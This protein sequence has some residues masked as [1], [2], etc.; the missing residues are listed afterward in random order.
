V[1][2]EVGARG[3]ANA[4]RCGASPRRRA[5]AR[6]AKGGQLVH[7][8]GRASRAK[9]PVVERVD[10]SLELLDLD[11]VAAQ[12]GIHDGRGER[13]RVER[14]DLREVVDLVVEPLERLDPA[15]ADGH[16]EVRRDHEVEPDE[17]EAALVR[18]LDAPQAQVNVPV[19]AAQQERLPRVASSS[20]VAGPRSHASATARSVA[21]SRPCTS[22]HSSWSSRSLRGRSSAG[23]SRGRIPRESYRL[24]LTGRPGQAR[25][26]GRCPRLSRPRTPSPASDR[27]A[28]GKEGG[29]RHTELEQQ[30]GHVVAQG[31]AMLAIRM[32][33]S[34]RATLRLPP[35]EPRTV[36]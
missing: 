15:V 3:R 29:C 33:A 24:V 10:P 25:R 34:L 9:G 5:A 32:G 12:D 4:S 30:H 23:R 17:L 2:G 16:D 31:R 11:E 22:T 28:G 6:A 7:H 27:S 35:V 14:P 26:V 1:E 20:V 8:R 19:V 13:R 18:A 36:P 21:G